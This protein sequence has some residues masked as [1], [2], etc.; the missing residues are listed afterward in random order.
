MQRNMKKALEMVIIDLYNI[1]V[2]CGVLE[3]FL[4]FFIPDAQLTLQYHWYRNI[5]AAVFNFLIGTIL[6][7]LDI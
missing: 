6:E 7:I 2:R 4:I 5:V 3:L 1:Y